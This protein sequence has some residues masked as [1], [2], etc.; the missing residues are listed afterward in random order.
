MKTQV[1]QLDSHDDII[2]IREKIAW[3]KTSRI[4]LVFPRR[5][6]LRLRNLD[7]RLLRRHAVLLGAQLAFVSRSPELRRLAKE[8]GIPSFRRVASAQ[9]KKWAQVAVPTAPQRQ[10]PPPDLWQM[11]REVY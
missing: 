3:A 11:R 9:R 5:S 10:S 2:S 1:I 6:H 4:L 8:E 7:L